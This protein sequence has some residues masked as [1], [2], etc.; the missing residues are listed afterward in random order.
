MGAGRA[1]AD[2]G[3]EPDDLFSDAAGSQPEALAADPAARRLRYVEVHFEALNPA[4][5]ALQSIEA[6][7]AELSLN[8]FDDTSFTARFERLQPTISGGFVLTGELDGVPFSQ[9]TLSV[10]NGALNGLV[11]T[12]EGSYRIHPVRPGLHLIAEDDPEGYPPS[13]QP[14]LPPILP[15]GQVGAMAGGDDD[16]SRIDVLVAYTDS[17]ANAMDGEAGI[18][19][20]IDLAVQHANIGYAN[21]QIDQRLHLVQAG[22]VSYNDTGLKNTD[23]FISTLTRLQSQGDGYMDAVHTW[24]E[25]SKADL[26]AL[27]V[28]PADAFVCGIGYL[29][30]EPTHTYFDY[31]AFSVTA[32]SCLGNHTFAHELGHNMGAHHNI[33]NAGGMEGYFPYSYGYLGPTFSTVMAYGGNRINYWSN[34]YVSYLGQA[35]GTASANNA[36]TLNNTAA[37]VAKF[38]DGLSPA[39]PA[40]LVAE[41]LDEGIRLTWVD[42]SSDEDSFRIERSPAGQGAWSEVG[43]VGADVTLFEQGGLPC[44]TRYDYRVYARSGNG[45][46]AYSNTA[47]IRTRSCGLPLPPAGLAASPHS[48]SSIRLDWQ[49]VAGGEIVYRVERLEGSLWQPL[50]VTAEDENYFIDRRL[51]QGSSYTYRVT[52]INDIGESDPS[53]AVQGSTFPYGLFMPMFR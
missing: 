20:A 33:E 12:F 4:L 1:A 13:A 17:A 47:T 3:D 27:I 18:L 22:R 28:G 42:N 24:R 39:A 26:V 15:A 29:M 5:E 35:T 23:W 38:R 52:A 2:A 40:A 31:Y 8:L 7:P 46:S 32:V 53:A 6:Q 19:T 49:A 50:G 34:P 41:R 16:G 44:S 36:L 45:S 25:N 10:L 30:S 9:V 37:I 21:S 51:S 48:V 14:L 43:S 11:S